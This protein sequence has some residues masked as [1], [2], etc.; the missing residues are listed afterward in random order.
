VIAFL[1]DFAF[2]L[3]ILLGLWANYRAHRDTVAALEAMAARV[4]ELEDEVES[5]WGD[6]PD[7]DPDDGEEPGVL[8]ED[9]EAVGEVIPLKR[10]S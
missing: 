6:P 4:A 10:A 9:T 8:T 5:L 7:D 2:N 3:A 1:C